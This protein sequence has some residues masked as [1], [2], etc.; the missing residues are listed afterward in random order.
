MCL[1]KWLHHPHPVYLCQVG[2][3]ENDMSW[4]ASTSCVLTSW[5]PVQ[6]RHQMFPM[7]VQNALRA[8]FRHNASFSIKVAC[9]PLE[10]I[11]PA[12][13]QRQPGRTASDVQ[14][15][16][17]GLNRELR[18]TVLAT[19]VDPTR[20]HWYRWLTG[21]LGWSSPVRAELFDANSPRKLSFLSCVKA[22]DS[23]GFVE[24][25]HRDWPIFQRLSWSAH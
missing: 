7:Y 4:V 11:K 2:L 16:A 20:I 13:S 25:C 10:A 23:W 5:V 15:H 21:K 19:I 17:E 18:A 3:C 24:V 9:R 12:A 22:K 6:L 14:A 8:F 1:D